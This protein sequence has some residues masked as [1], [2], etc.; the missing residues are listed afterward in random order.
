MVVG[1]THPAATVAIDGRVVRVAADGTFVFGIGRDAASPLVVTV[2]QPATRVVE[3]RIAVAP[4][5]WPVERIVGVPPETVNPPPEIAARIER[6]Q[7]LVSAARVR[8][9]A[10][11]DFT[12]QF[13]WPVHG[14]ISGRFGNQRVY[15][16]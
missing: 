6:E 1:S 14:R 8:D 2:K 9:D 12:R 5:D 3:H 13:A 4:R 16:L 11:E 10:R 7:A 15:V